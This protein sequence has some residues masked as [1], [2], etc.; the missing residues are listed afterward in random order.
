MKN[1]IIILTIIILTACNKNP[2]GTIENIYYL[3]VQ[4]NTNLE[5]TVGFFHD[6]EF[7]LEYTVPPLQTIE[8]DSF[9]STSSKM[10]IGC[11]VTYTNPSININTDRIC[12]FGIW[13]SRATEMAYDFEGIKLIDLQSSKIV[14]YADCDT[15]SNNLNVCNIG[16]E[17]KLEEAITDKIWGVTSTT[18]YI[19]TNQQ[20]LLADSL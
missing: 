4:N 12:L 17:E 19:I 2:S 13:N 15:S 9:K 3:K 7:L 10:D 5:V 20:Y 16:Y 6:S 8:L 18:T 1:L 11:S 14:S